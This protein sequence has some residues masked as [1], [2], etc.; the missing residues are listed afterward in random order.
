MSEKEQPGSWIFSKSVE[1]SGQT[2]E[3]LATM[4]ERVE[5]YIE[6]MFAR[7]PLACLYLILYAGAGPNAFRKWKELYAQ[8]G[9]TG[10]SG[11]TES[12]DKIKMILGCNLT[13]D[14][15]SRGMTLE[16][17]ASLAGARSQNVGKIMK[18]YVKD[19]LKIKSQLNWARR[20]E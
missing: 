2:P 14:E 4:A 15:L 8:A 20:T 5:K 1:G 6:V 9:E 19:S 17:V 7:H 10:A 12:T 11:L 3:D 13:D 16:E 18:L